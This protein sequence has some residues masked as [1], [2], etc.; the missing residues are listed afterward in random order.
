MRALPTAE[1]EGSPIRPWSSWSLP[2]PEPVA[3]PGGI[4]RN[5]GVAVARVLELQGSRL[6]QLPPQES[7]AVA[8]DFIPATA[9][10][11]TARPARTLLV[12]VRKAD[13]D[14][15]AAGAIDATEFT[16]RVEIVEY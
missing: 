3:D 8:I 2:Q 1:E 15:R 12:R 14:A 13:I 6:V 11:A 5:V 16:K 7:V 10:V 4:I 9:Q